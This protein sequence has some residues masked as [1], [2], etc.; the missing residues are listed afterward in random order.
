MLGIIASTNLPFVMTN[1]SP[2]SRFVVIEE[3]GINK[4][5]NLLSPKISSKKYFIFLSFSSF[6]MIVV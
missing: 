2:F 6:F 5:L 3:N 1:S 4:S